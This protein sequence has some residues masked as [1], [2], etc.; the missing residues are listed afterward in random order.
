MLNKMLK[1]ALLIA[2]AVTISACN[3]NEAKPAAAQSGS[4]HLQEIIQK[5]ELVLGTSGNMTPMTR[6]IDDGKDAV[7]FDI[8]L[9]RA[10][11]ETMGVKL[12]V[13]VIAFE[14]L[15]PA[16]EN[17]EIDIIVSNMTI[18][19]KRNTKVLFVGPYLVSGKCLITSEADLANAKSEEVN[20]ATNKIVV[21]KGTTDETF[22][23]VVMPKVEAVTVTTQEEAVEMVRNGSVTAMLSEFPICKSIITSNPDD[24]FIAAFSNLTYEPIGVAIAPQNAHLENWTQNFMLRANQAGLFKVLSQKWFK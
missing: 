22:V 5:G 1:T 3:G 12:V 17:G 23:K 21:L 11:A 9:A 14:K 4:T 16:L 13:K 18:T 20:R 15:I 10:M 2:L 7:G 8:D 24:N 19:P 6:S